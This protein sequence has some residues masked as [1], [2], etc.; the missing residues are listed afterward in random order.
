MS[1]YFKPKYLPVHILG[2][3]R[4][5]HKDIPSKKC[6]CFCWNFTENRCKQG[7]LQEPEENRR[8]SD[9]SLYTL[10]IYVVTCQVPIPE[11]VNIKSLNNPEWSREDSS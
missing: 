10:F 11:T 6:S 9:G 1:Q 4:I 8:A 5:L 3:T 7:H 2:S